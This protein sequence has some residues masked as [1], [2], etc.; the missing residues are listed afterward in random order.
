MSKIT[1][2][3]SIKYEQVSTTFLKNNIEDRAL[4]I[5][6]QLCL[7]I[8]KHIKSHSFGHLFNELGVKPQLR[9]TAI[10]HRWHVPARPNITI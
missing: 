3:V 8:A 5:W 7:F 2:L 10:T 1:V 9:S 4:L 6:S